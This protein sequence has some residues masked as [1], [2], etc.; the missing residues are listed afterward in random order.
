MEFARKLRLAGAAGA[1]MAVLAIEPAA[2]TGRCGGS[3]AIDAAT[4]LAEV[5]R[6]CN[7]N[8][9]ALYEANPGVDPRHVRPGTYLAMPDE[10]DAFAP[11]GA[12]SVPTIVTAND[13]TDQ[14]RDP[15]TDDHGLGGRYVNE[16][17]RAVD[18]RLSTRARVRDARLASTDPVWLRE[19]TGGGARSYAADRLSYQQRSAARIHSAGVPS[20]LAPRNPVLRRETAAVASGAPE[21][22]ACNVLHGDEDGK[23]RKVRKIISTPTNTFVEVEPIPSGG[24]ECTLISAPDPDAVPLTPGVPAAHYNLPPKVIAPA[25]RDRA[26]YRLPN[27][28]TINPGATAKK[29]SLSG[30]VVGEENGCLMLRADDGHVWALAAAPG[31]DTLV[32]KHVTAWGV[33]SVSGACGAAPTLIVSHAVFAEPWR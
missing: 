6:R 2:A 30:D 7:V 23:R 12:P 33:S 28:N 32:G 14:Q 26:G 10:I 29:I 17:R 13:A 15:I 25:A 24:F 27:Y 4:S 11:S 22:I 20:S 18:A 8:L 5:A 9:S 31:A 19:A 21:L 16:S 1:T 3:L